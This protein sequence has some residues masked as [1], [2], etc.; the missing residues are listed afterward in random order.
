MLK[1]PST[2]DLYLLMVQMIIIKLP[3][4]VAALEGSDVLSATFL[5]DHWYEASNTKSINQLLIPYLFHNVFL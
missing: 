3:S 5:H 1:N 2:I 4:A